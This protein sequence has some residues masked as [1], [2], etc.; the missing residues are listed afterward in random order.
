MGETISIW[1]KENEETFIIA[2]FTEDVLFGSRSY[3]AFDLPQEKFYELQRK[4]GAQNKATIVMI[5]GTE[6]VEELSDAFTK[7]VAERGDNLEFYSNTDK[8]YAKE[9]RTSNISVYMIIIKILIQLSN[10]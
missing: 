1:F 2:G 7:F 8:I 4:V 9:S 6:D 10:L 5:Q 3:L